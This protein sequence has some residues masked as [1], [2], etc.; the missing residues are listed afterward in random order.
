MHVAATSAQEN[1][2]TA[3]M[4]A[5]KILIRELNSVR[6]CQIRHI[7]AVIDHVSETRAKLPC[8]ISEGIRTICWD[9]LFDLIIKLTTV[10]FLFGI[11][12]RLQ[13]RLTSFAL[14]SPFHW[15]PLDLLGH[16]MVYERIF[17]SA[18]KSSNMS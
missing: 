18:A 2:E 7:S 14:S 6:F 4:L 11:L 13:I 3:V 16:L 8:R 15:Q 10:K 5:D 1:K 17:L 9:F 12:K